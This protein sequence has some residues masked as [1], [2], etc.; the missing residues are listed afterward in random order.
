MH[1]ACQMSISSNQSLP[2]PLPILSWRRIYLL[3]PTK[4]NS[5]TTIK[6]HPLSFHNPQPTTGNSQQSKASLEILYSWILNVFST[7]VI[8]AHNF[9]P[10]LTIRLH[11]LPAHHPVTRGKKSQQNQNPE[12]SFSTIAPAH[13]MILFPDIPDMLIINI[14]NKK[15]PSSGY[16]YPPLLTPQTWT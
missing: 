9:I 10:I 11:H 15:S 3:L 1:I 4:S 6:T 16:F 5:Q 8:N 12:P 14:N 13:A 2:Y 7:P